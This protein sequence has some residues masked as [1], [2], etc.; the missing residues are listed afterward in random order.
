M[1]AIRIVHRR[2]LVCPRGHSLHDKDASSTFRWGFL[3]YVCRDCQPRSYGVAVVCDQP[4]PLAIVVDTTQAEL[5]AWQ[6][7]QVLE[8]MDTV[9]LLDFFKVRP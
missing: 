3:T 4:T 2:A 5:K 1:N 6:E 8:P 7:R 9:E